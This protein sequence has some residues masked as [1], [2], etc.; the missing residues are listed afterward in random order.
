MKKMKN[1][2][3][4]E[5]LGWNGGLPDSVVQAML[6]RGNIAFS[7]AEE[8]P[9]Q[10]ADEDHLPP[11]S[12]LTNDE[13][14]EK[15]AEFRAPGTYNIIVNPSSF[16]DL[17]EYRD[18]SFYSNTASGWKTSSPNQRD[19]Q[20]NKTGMSSIHSNKHLEED[21]NVVILGKFEGDAMNMPVTDIRHP[22]SSASAMTSQSSSR[23]V[24]PRATLNPLFNQTVTAQI[25]LQIPPGK[26]DDSRLVAHFNRFVL[27]SIAQVHRDALG[28][29]ADTNTL[30]AHEVFA[31]NA[32]HFSP[33]RVSTLNTAW[34][35][36]AAVINIGQT[37]RRVSIALSRLDGPYG[38]EHG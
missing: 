35:T 19:H 38:S 29:E 23:Q 34:N 8:L 10:D 30:L 11:F 18:S 12:S 1:R 3:C 32:A 24:S 26:D 13:D 36:W 37:D 6:I 28:T 33:V 16:V 14:R 20:S 22:Q 15:K 17:E 31:Q 7:V 21:P 9:I 27:P 25:L 2:G 4:T 5:S